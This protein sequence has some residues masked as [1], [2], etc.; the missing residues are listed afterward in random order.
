MDGKVELDGEKNTYGK[1]VDVNQG[2]SPG[3]E[4][5]HTLLEA[6]QLR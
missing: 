6:N 4:S 5:C 3:G 2:R 1:N